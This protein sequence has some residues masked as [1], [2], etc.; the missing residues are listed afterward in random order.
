MPR[1]TLLPVLFTLACGLPEN[2]EVVREIQWADAQTEALARRACYDC[3]SNEVRLPWYGETKALFDRA[4]AD[5]HSNETH[6]K[7]SHRW[8]IVNS[9]VRSDIKRGRCHM[10]FSEWDGPNEDAWEAP[11]AVLDGEMPLGI[12]K[13]THPDARLTDEERLLLAE[14]FEATFAQDPPQDGERCDD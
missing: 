13:S 3:H 9:L 7:D 8:P 2:P 10:N 14:G 5:C 4:C 1:L 11:E 12:Y 6:W